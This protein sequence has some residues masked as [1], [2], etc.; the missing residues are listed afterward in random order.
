LIGSKNIPLIGDA[1]YD[2][3]DAA[4]A[5]P[6]VAL[7]ISKTCIKPPRSLT[8]ILLFSLSAAKPVKPC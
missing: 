4:N 8:N 2:D 6:N 3:T 5:G 7:V 1:V